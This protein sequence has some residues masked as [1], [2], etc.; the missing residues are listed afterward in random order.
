MLHELNKL[1]NLAERAE[2]LDKRLEMNTTPTCPNVEGE[3][4]KTRYGYNL[5]WTCPV[6][7]QYL[8][9]DGEFIRHGD[10]IVHD[11]ME[12]HSETILYTVTAKV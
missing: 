1:N 5:S 2:A 6:S 4:N 8:E 9:A 7:G 12:E 10:H 3:A 11:V